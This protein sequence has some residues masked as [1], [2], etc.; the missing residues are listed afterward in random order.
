MIDSDT[1]LKKKET[2]DHSGV[3]FA[4]PFHQTET[5][6]SYFSLSQE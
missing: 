6:C 1:R 5:N 3:T 4:R 2:T